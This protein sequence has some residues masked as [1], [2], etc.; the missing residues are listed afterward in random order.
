MEKLE[1][2]KY[3]IARVLSVRKLSTAHLL[4]KITHYSTPPHQHSSWEFVFCEHGRVAAYT[5][6]EEYILKDNQ[7]VFHPPGHNHSI[8]VD[9]EE[10]TLFV[11]AFVC[12]SKTMKLLQNRLLD[13]SGEQHRLLNLIIQELYNAFELS[14]GKL[15]LGDFYPNSNAPLGAEQMVSC[16]LENLLI[17]LLRSSAGQLYDNPVMLKDALEARIGYELKEYIVKH[18][19]ERITLETL[20][21]RFHYS[22]SH[23][24]AQFRDY[25]GMSIITFTSRLRI[26]RAKELLRSGDMTVSQIS[27]SLGYSSMA[28]F[29]QCFKKAVGCC[30]TEYAKTQSPLSK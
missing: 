22:Q 19:N 27:D 12:T 14:D 6:V 4:P 2:H 10:T 15:L 30:P 17:S 1:F 13:V 28:Y 18:L 29:S 16:Y 23:I 7:I 20:S 11:M 5:D 24:T 25:T 26:E 3:R 9:K 21:E 8:Q